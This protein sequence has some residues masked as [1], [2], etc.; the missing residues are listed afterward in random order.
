MADAR[1]LLYR[2]KSLDKAANSIVFFLNQYV[3]L[4]DKMYEFKTLKFFTK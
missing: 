3:I 4:L 1:K 2:I